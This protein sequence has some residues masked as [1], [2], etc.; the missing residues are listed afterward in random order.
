MPDTLGWSS[1]AAAAPLSRTHVSTRSSFVTKIITDFAYDM[2]KSYAGCMVLISCSIGHPSKAIFGLILRAKID[3]L[4]ITQNCFGISDDTISRTSLQL[5]SYVSTFM[6][7][8]DLLCMYMLASLMLPLSSRL[9]LIQSTDTF[10]TL[11]RLSNAV[12]SL[13]NRRLH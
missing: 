7:Q 8:S 4:A 10:A 2:C 9:N 6:V 12:I 5:L 11:W 13:P 1:T 3:C